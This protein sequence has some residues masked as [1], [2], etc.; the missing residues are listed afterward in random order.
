VDGYAAAAPN[1]YIGVRARC[2][3]IV[4]ESLDRLKE[5][6]AESNDEFSKPTRFA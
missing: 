2:P 5:I 3:T 4:M 6:L 1:S